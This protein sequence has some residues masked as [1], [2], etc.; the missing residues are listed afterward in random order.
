MSKLIFA[1]I[2]LAALY[3]LA[4][5]GVYQMNGAY[6]LNRLTGEVSLCNGSY[7]KVMGEQ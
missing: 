5:H 7:C 2:A 3:L 1:G 4:L 6:R